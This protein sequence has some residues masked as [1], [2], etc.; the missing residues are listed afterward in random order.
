MSNSS[1]SAEAQPSN[2]HFDQ[3]SPR[4]QRRIARLIVGQAYARRIAT[5]DFAVLSSWRNSESVVATFAKKDVKAAEEWCLNFLKVGFYVAVAYR[6][7]RTW[8]GPIPCAS[9]GRYQRPF[10][11]A[12]PYEHAEGCAIFSCRPCNCLARVKR[13]AAGKRKPL[14]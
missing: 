13:R 10:E 2:N 14:H 3:L 5:L 1:P 4:D 12:R 11:F 8:S 6:K 7:G 9:D